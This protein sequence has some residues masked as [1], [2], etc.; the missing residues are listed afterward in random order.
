MFRHV[1]VVPNFTVRSPGSKKC[2]A[3]ETVALT[4][5]GVG[6]ARALAGDGTTVTEG[7][8]SYEPHPAII[9]SLWTKADS[10]TCFDD[11]VVKPGV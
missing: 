2:S 6:T 9:L 4:F 3:M 5:G 7:G 8:R 1:T 11:V 10:V